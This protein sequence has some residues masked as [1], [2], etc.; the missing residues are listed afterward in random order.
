MGEVKDWRLV[1]L[2]AGKESFA[3]ELKY[4][5]ICGKPFIP[6]V[7]TQKMCSNEC[8]TENNRKKNKLAKQKKAREKR[9]ERAKLVY[10]CIV[11]GKKFHPVATTSTCCSQECK[12]KNKRIK[13]RELAR[14]YR[15]AEKRYLPKSKPR[16][17]QKVEDI[18]SIQRKAQK[19]GMSYGQY[20]AR[21]GS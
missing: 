1:G 21:N 7:P 10:T 4:C 12:K 2:A 9:E 19:L 11:C 3:V 20:V 8:R 6:V 18:T 5:K 16:K 17:K 15:E 14:S 13:D